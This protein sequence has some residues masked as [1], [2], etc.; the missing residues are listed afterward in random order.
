[1]KICKVRSWFFWGGGVGW[2]R[3]RNAVGWGTALQ[4]WKSRVLFRIVSFDFF[5]DKIL[6][7]ALWP[8]GWLCLW[9]K[10]VPGIFP[11]GKGGRFVGLTNLP[12]SCRLSWNMGAPT[13]WNPHCLSRPV[14]RLFYSVGLSN[15]RWT[16]LVLHLV[17]VETTDRL[18]TPFFY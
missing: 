2:G 17:S 1:M 6:P 5:I 10:W 11:G 14:M 3:R 8:C 12:P 15:R 13:S 7:P 4:A 16:V 9:Q 18:T